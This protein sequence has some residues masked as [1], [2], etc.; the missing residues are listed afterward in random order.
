M[1]YRSWILPALVV[2]AL[3]AAAIVKGGHAPLGLRTPERETQSPGWVPP[4]AD[5]GKAE[6]LQGPVNESRNTAIVQ[7]ARRVAPS[8]VSV[9]VTRREQVQPRSLFESFFLPPGAEQETQGLGSG[10]V[11]RE[12][13]LVLTNEHVVRGAQQVVVTL[14]DGR[15]FQGKVLGVDEVSDLALVKVDSKGLAVAPLGTS[16]SLMIGEWVVAIGN[17]FGFWLSNTEPTV[18]AGVVSGVDRN[19]IGAGG[20]TTASAVPGRGRLRTVDASDDAPHGYY[21][22]MIQTDAAINP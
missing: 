19:I 17:P 22:D 20:A 6:H 10:F 8:V 14:P 21:L 9:N 1:A 3:G 18:T 7:A 5:F 12:D 11:I 13:G 4:V 16:D 2:L 15:Q